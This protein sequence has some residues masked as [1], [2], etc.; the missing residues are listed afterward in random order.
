M[1]DYESLASQV[2]I[3]IHR[4]EYSLTHA[5]RVEKIDLLDLR[6]NYRDTL[7][8]LY[9]TVSTTYSLAMFKRTN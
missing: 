1:L 9:T 8:S 6:V 7:P 3:Y 5:R 4:T 2:H